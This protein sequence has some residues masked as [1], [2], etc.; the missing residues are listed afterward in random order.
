MPTTLTSFADSEIR[1]RYREPF[2]T[3]GLDLKL[4]VNTPPGIYRGFRLSTE[5]SALTISVV[6]D[7]VFSDHSAVYQSATGHS[8]SI[9]RV[10]GLFTLDLSAY[11][12]K[13]VVIAIYCT[14]VLGSPTVGDLRAY[15][16]APTDEFTLAAE[17]P[18]LVVLGTVV[19][20]GAGLIPAAN[21]THARRV[22]AWGTV[23]P[24][25]TP[26]QPVIK[27]GGFEYA[28]NGQSYRHAI[29][30]WE[31]ITS[32]NGTWRAY[33]SGFG[34]YSGG[35][36]LQ[37]TLTSSPVT[38]LLTQRLGFACPEG[39]LVRVSTWVRAIIAPTLSANVNV[40]F[41][42]ADTTGVPF[43]STSVP[44]VAVGGTDAGY[45][46]VDSIVAAP[47]TTAFL[48]SVDIFA[49]AQ[50]Y[51][52]TGI[53]LLVDDF[54]VFVESGGP[55]DT[56]PDDMRNGVPRVT[57][58]IV[59]DPATLDPSQIAA[60]VRFDKSSPSGEGTVYLD[61][62]D[63][64]NASLP[65][66][67]ALLGRLSLGANLL[68]TE[69]DALKAR[70]TSLYG[71]AGGIDYTLLHASP[72]VS[73][74]TQTLRLYASPT[75][76]IVWTVNARWGS[77][78]ANQWNKDVNG[79]PASKV[80]QQG[81]KFAIYSQIGTTN[82]WVDAAWQTNT[83]FLG[84]LSSVLGP[85][86]NLSR[87]GIGADNGVFINPDGRIN[88]AFR[89]TRYDAINFD[90]ANSLSFWN[91]TNISGGQV[92]IA[93]NDGEAIL[94]IESGSLLNQRASVVMGGGNGS[95]PAFPVT[96]RP[97]FTVKFK[98]IG[99]V[100][101]RRDFVG[102]T[103]GG[104]YYNGSSPMCILLHDTALSPNFL[105][106]YEDTTNAEFSYDTGLVAVADVWYYATLIVLSQSPGSFLL[107]I[108]TT[109]D[110]R[111]GDTVTV[112]T[113]LLGNGNLQPDDSGFNWRLGMGVTTLTSSI[114]TLDLS[115]IEVFATKEWD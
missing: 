89:R 93:N 61:R 28:D 80:E 97:G 109:P 3:E 69:T 41:N 12:S 107:R 76:N 46:N 70:V 37:L 106:R 47:A 84:A 79:S 25:A 75:G 49:N 54:Q 14:Y 104:G 73:G 95:R 27:N 64:N 60:L 17:R 67:L 9:R 45:R 7:A 23:A 22:S 92:Y 63:Q 15:E 103:D 96:T 48:H 31:V 59:D 38:A 78:T 86:V 29:A 51:G 53:A 20:P 55:I 88:Q 87:P 6:S 24:E 18:E 115:W 111:T 74:S 1:M 13:T 57:S 26:W 2:L 50:T 34:P 44:L 71:I 102:F 108:G 91:N 4:A 19:V 100:A 90:T 8:L 56:R 62:K 32:T 81:D 5:A 40:V 68:A 72:P 52:A 83:S 42:W 33:D 94:H 101:N 66:A 105:V 98:I 65:P 30:D 114:Q 112:Q 36:S 10:G 21:I 39:R 110:W 43:A 11:A 16:L 85:S 99:T 77:P 58:L 35:K 113:S 82:T